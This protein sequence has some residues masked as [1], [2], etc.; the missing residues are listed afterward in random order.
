MSLTLP[1]DKDE[2]N[3]NL[4]EVSYLMKK[5][6]GVV[7]S[8]VSRQGCPLSLLLFNAMMK[9]IANFLIRENT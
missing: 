7:P 2:Q 3:L 1:N 5:P 4:Y 8:L 9:I 6:L